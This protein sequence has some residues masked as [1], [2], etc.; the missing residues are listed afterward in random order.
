MRVFIVPQGINTLAH[1]LA[2]YDDLYCQNVYNFFNSNTLLGLQASSKK[3]NKDFALL[4][5]S[6]I[7]QD[8]SNFGN[9]TTKR[10]QSNSAA[11]MIDRSIQNYLKDAIRNV[12][13][14]IFK[15]EINNGKVQPIYFTSRVELGYAKSKGN[16]SVYDKL[17]AI[18][19]IVNASNMN[20]CNE[21]FDLIKNQGG[22]PDGIDQV[23]KEIHSNIP[24]RQDSKAPGGGSKSE[25]EKANQAGGTKLS[26]STK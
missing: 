22:F 21:A 25:K 6:L 10:L 23:S 1:W 11:Q 8:S 2:M 3:G 17:E 16:A 18:R 15:V 4:A 24:A 26:E 7:N 20:E 19:G 13:I 14:K 5:D 12:D 9:D